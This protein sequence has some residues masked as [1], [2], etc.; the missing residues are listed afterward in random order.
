VTGALRRWG[1]VLGV[2]AALGAQFLLQRPL[3]RANQVRAARRLQTAPSSLAFRLAAGGVKEAA[4]DALWLTILPRLGKPWEVPERKAAWIESFAGVLADANP[5]AHFPLVYATSFLEFVDRRH[6]AIERML[7]HAMEIEKR[8][9]F[10]VTTRPNAEDWELPEALGMNLVLHGRTPAERARGLAYLR[11]AASRPTCYTLLVDYVDRMGEREGYALMGWDLYLVRASHAGAADLRDHY[12]KEADRARLDVLRRWA[13]AA[14]E[15]LGRWPGNLDE[16]LAAAP[17]AV[18]DELRRVPDR[19]RDLLDGV[20]V[21][22][23]TRDLAID[24][25]TEK[26]VRDGMSGLVQ[27]IRAFEAARGRRPKDLRDLENGIGTRFSPPP[28]HGT[29]WALDPGT[30]APSIVPDPSDPRVKP[31]SLVK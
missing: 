15:R 7:L 2:A 23:D 12:L 20:R 11:Q 9:P 10:G 28:R 6:P 16:V 8:G 3:A 19:R 30:A 31:P 22:P 18:A 26:Q 17:P 24:T 13:L 4:A 14:E 29:R 1:V 5:R 21:L 27:A 25:L